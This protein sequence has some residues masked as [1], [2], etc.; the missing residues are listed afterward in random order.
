MKFD[1]KELR[2][3]PDIFI[4]QTTNNELILIEL[5]A[6]RV[7]ITHKILNEVLENISLRFL[8]HYE[9]RIIPSILFEP[10]VFH[11]KE[12]KTCQL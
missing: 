9:N 8:R 1:D 12:E 10:F 2:K 7:E 4:P 5:K 3:I 11:L 6:P